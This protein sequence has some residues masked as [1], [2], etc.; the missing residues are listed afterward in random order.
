M[1]IVRSEGFTVSFCV[2]RYHHFTTI[3]N[4]NWY[5]VITMMIPMNLSILLSSCTIHHQYRH[6]HH[7]QLLL[8]Y[9]DYQN[10]HYFIIIVTAVFINGVPKN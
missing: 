8:S 9:N 6:G 1:D 4:V 10:S 3:V 5:S 2:C 7:Y